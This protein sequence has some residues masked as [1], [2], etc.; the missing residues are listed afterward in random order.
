MMNRR[1]ISH[2]NAYE[3]TKNMSWLGASKIMYYK[4]N[5]IFYYN[6]F[7]K[8]LLSGGSYCHSRAMRRPS[9]RLHA[10]GCV[11]P[12]LLQI[13]SRRRTAVPRRWRLR[14]DRHGAKA[15]LPSARTVTRDSTEALHGNSDPTDRIGTRSAPTATARII[16]LGFNSLA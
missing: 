12:R 13:R 8:T 10:P 15:R 3:Y 16:P 9:V 11:R 7:C 1:L 4:S 5:T 2:K 14:R 6:A